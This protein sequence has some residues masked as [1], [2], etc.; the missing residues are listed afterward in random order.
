MVFE[1]INR[2]LKEKVSYSYRLSN[3]LTSIDLVTIGSDHRSISAGAKSI[4]SEMKN[5]SKKEDPNS[6]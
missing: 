5:H 6:Y 3:S 1:D 2:I 4:I